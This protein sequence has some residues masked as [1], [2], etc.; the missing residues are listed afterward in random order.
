[1]FQAYMFVII[2]FCMKYFVMLSLKRWLKKRFSEIQVGELNVIK[3]M[4]ICL[5]ITFSYEL[6]D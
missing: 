2:C 5:F 4:Y 1:M 3:F 6:V